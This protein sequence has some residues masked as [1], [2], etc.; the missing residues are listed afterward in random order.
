MLRLS[1]SRT[2]GA[3]RWRAVARL[4]GQRFPGVLIQGGSLHPPQRRLRG[5]RTR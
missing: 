2:T 1:C 4:P 3:T 5:F